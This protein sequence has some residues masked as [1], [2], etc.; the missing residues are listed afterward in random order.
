MAVE[1]D[2]EYVHIQSRNGKLVDLY[3]LNSETGFVSQ[4]T[5]EIESVERILQDRLSSAHESLKDSEVFLGLNIATSAVLFVEAIRRRSK[6]LIAASLIPAA[7][8]VYADSVRK[9]RWREIVWV[10]KEMMGMEDHKDSV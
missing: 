7:G 5:F 9:N 10:E 6:V 1:Q 2:A 3:R 4:E 8:A